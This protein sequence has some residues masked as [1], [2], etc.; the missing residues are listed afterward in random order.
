MNVQLIITLAV[1]VGMVL[2]FL[3]GRFKLG[4]VAMTATTV[5][6]LTGVLTFDEAYSYLSNTNIVLLGALFVLSGALGRTSLVLK[7]RQWVMN[8]SGKGQM[9]VFAYLIICAVMTNLSSPLAI[10]SMLLP[11]MTALGPESD[12]Q[13]SHLLYPGAVIGHACQGALPIG[14]F[15]LMVNALLEANGVSSEQM[16]SVVDYAKVVAVPGIISILYMGLIG[17]RF[18]PVNKIDE[19]QIAG[20]KGNANSVYYQPMQENYVYIAFILVFVGLFFKSYL[21]FDVAALAVAAVVVLMYL[22]VLDLNDVK[23]FLNL[24]ALFMLVGVM[25]LGTA[26]QNTGAGDLVADVIVNLLGSNPSPLMILIAFYIA[27]AILTQFMSNTATAT[28]FATLGI[29]TAISRGIDPRPFG[30]AIYAGATAAMLSPTG[31]PS[32]AIAFGAGHYKIKDVL[33]ACL[34]LWIIYGVAMILTA[35]FWYPI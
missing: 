15:F 5:L 12:I 6:H 31:S 11:F 20:K 32:I 19:A 18:F 3:S 22:N 29:V 28:I 34:P 9:I 33:K 24:D 30:I 13:P 2:G 10:L 23:N 25:P 1:I 8:H 14:T 17:W 35:T 27:A 21:P 7:L 26:M 4:L 16:L